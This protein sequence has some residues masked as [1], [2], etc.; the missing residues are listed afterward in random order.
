M[1]I[2]IYNCPRG[3]YSY[4]PTFGN[5]R[6]VKKTRIVFHDGGELPKNLTAKVEIISVFDPPGT[7]D[8][9]KAFYQ[10]HGIDLT[11]SY[12]KMR[13]EEFHALDFPTFI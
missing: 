4:A 13:D 2:R 1:T 8:E 3:A 11:A 12:I 10:E 9:D 6:E 5:V 7:Y